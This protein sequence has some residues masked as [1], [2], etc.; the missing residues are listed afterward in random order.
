MVD[1]IEE[2]VGMVLK[3]AKDA[4]PDEIRQEFE[5]YQ[6]EFLIP[7]KDA[8]RSV[9]RRFEVS[10]EVVQSA[11][12]TAHRASKRAERFEELGADDNDVTIEVKVVTYTPRVQTVRG[13]ERQIAFGWIEDAPYGGGDSVRWDFKDWG[14]HSENMAPGSIVRLEGVS[15]NEWQG[16]KSLNVNAS[17]RVVILEEG[18]KAVSVATSDPI[19]IEAAM[20][21]EGFVTVVGRVMSCKPQVINKRDGSGTL[22]IIRGKLADDTGS[23]GFVSW[24]E[25]EHEVGSLLRIEGAS[26]RRFRDTPE[27]NISDNTKVEQFHDEAFVDMTSLE[28]SSRLQIADL[29]DGARDV[30]AVV[31]VVDWKRRDFT[32]QQGEEKTLW[33]GEVIDETGRC[34]MTAWEELPF[35]E[36]KLPVFCSL[37]SV[38]VR[39]WQGTPD[40]T[41]DSTS[42]VEMLD[43]APWDEIDS[44]NHWVKHDLGAMVRGGSVSG[45]ETL[46]AIV[47]VRNDSGI[48]YRCPECRRVMRSGAC[49]EHGSM[50]GVQDLRLRMVVDDGIG[51]ASLLFNRDASESLLGK[52]M[53]EVEEEIDRGQDEFILALRSKYLGRT[54]MVRGRCLVDDQGAMFLAESMEP[55]ST[56]PDEI[57]AEVR[58]KWGVSA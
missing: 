50:E 49:N 58:K 5:K 1:E 32:N 20:E 45:V 2:F 21:S 40:I 36:S 8:F 11:A 28:A 18:G 19:S 4:D 39:A 26:V 31:Q 55:E 16:K 17:S 53:S 54:V 35:D 52:S 6:K 30:S 23:I 29:R 24:A 56:P 14:N 7:P 34:R 37:S 51:S 12:R 47:S 57:A 9:L 22:D 38:R 46:G 13:E 10:E 27:L 41:I 43:E 48:I 33:S 44:S 15:V 42:Q 3:E 25:F